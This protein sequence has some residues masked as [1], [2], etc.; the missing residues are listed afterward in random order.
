M[1]A[2]MTNQL[3]AEGQESIR[4]EKTSMKICGWISIKT[5]T[6]G[7]IQKLVVKRAQG[8][9]EIWKRFSL[10][11]LWLESDPASGSRL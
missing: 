4:D 5:S 9:D 3:D 2:A 10:A 7:Y 11:V 1:N 8:T 6:A